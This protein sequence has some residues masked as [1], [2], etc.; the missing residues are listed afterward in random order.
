VARVVVVEVEAV[1]GVRSEGPKHT[2]TTAS[3]A[4]SCATRSQAWP[5]R[6]RRRES[7]S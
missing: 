3:S 7:I 1:V 5:K 2:S 6:M 4:Y